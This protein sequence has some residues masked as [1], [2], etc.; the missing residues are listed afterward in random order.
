MK[1]TLGTAIASLAL[2]TGCAGIGSAALSTPAFAASN[3]HTM[4]THSWHGTI[5][6]VHAMMG[7]HGSFTLEVGA[8]NYTVDYTTMTKFTMGSSK[9]IKAGGMIG[10]TGTLTK[11]VISA[12]K[13]SL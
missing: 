7:T 13:L 5:G 11:G 4:M 3:S 1:K 8:K 10:V 6:M 9:D 12:T 2:L